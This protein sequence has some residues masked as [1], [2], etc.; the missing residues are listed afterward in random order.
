MSIKQLRSSTH[1]S[2][3]RSDYRN[4]VKRFVIDSFRADVKNEGDITSQALCG[5]IKIIAEIISKEEGIIAGIEEIDF[6]IKNWNKNIHVIW[7]KKTGDIVKK[8]QKV[9]ILEGCAKDILEIERTVLNVL[10]RMSAIATQTH[11]LSQKVKKYNPSVTLAATRKTVMGLLD[12]RA[13]EIGSGFPH[14]ANL[15]D[16]FLVKDTHMTIFKNDIEKIFEKI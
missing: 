4:D 12:K 7:K 3:K 11:R 6:S 15:N 8:G 10:Q 9:G 1:L 16:A 14:R 2:L 5:R 13:V